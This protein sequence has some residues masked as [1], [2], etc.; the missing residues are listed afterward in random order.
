MTIKNS[1]T[2]YLCDAGES[3]LGTP[4]TASFTQTM[5]QTFQQQGMLEFVDYLALSGSDL[6][7]DGYKYVLSA[8][9]SPLMDTVLSLIQ[10]RVELPRLVGMA[11]KQDKRSEKASAVNLRAGTPAMVGNIE[12]V[13]S[14]GLAPNEKQAVTHLIQGIHAKRIEE[15]HL[16][17]CGEG[18]GLAIELAHA[19]Q[20]LFPALPVN[21]LCL[22][23]LPSTPVSSEARLILPPNVKRFNAL[24]AL[25]D[26]RLARIPVFPCSQTTYQ[27]TEISVGTVR[28]F[29]LE[30]ESSA[31]ATLHQWQLLEQAPVPLEVGVSNEDPPKTV[32]TRYIHQGGLGIR[33]FAAIPAFRLNAFDQRNAY[34]DATPD[35]ST[36]DR[37]RKDRILAQRFMEGTLRHEGEVIFDFH[38][39]APL[40]AGSR[41]EWVLLASYLTGRAKT[42]GKNDRLLQQ[43]LDLVQKK[44]RREIHRAMVIGEKIEDP[45]LL[46]MA[47]A[48]GERA[49]FHKN[50]AEVMDHQDRFG[51]TALIIAA[52]N[53]HLAF[54][55]A[56]MQQ[57]KKPN[58]VLSNKEGYNALQIAAMQGH[59]G[60]M[61]VLFNG[62]KSWTEFALLDAAKLAATHH[63]PAV[64]EGVM[65]SL[66]NEKQPSLS[67][68]IN[69]RE[70]LICAL[71]HDRCE[72]MQSLIKNSHYQVDQPACPSTGKSLLA[73]SKS[74][75]SPEARAYLQRV[76]A[77]QT[78][79]PPEPQ[80][81]GN[82]AVA[83]LAGVIALGGLIELGIFFAGHGAV[84]LSGWPHAIPLIMAVVTV[85]AMITLVY[86]WP[87]SAVPLMKLDLK[88]IEMNEMGD[89]LDKKASL[90][91]TSRLYS[92]APV[93]VSSEPFVNQ[94]DQ[95]QNRQQSQR[96]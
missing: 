4:T 17:G 50:T 95:R 58:K 63:Q 10:G 82:L 15:V 66:L 80:P 64:V 54:V 79:A 36:L 76:H 30:A 96:Y 3:S 19:L 16:I 33:P 77:Q 85:V 57:E 60:I 86:H 49:I 52:R 75:G 81:R 78:Q 46:L 55:Q 37:D 25:N 90:L 72:L 31:L 38:E 83:S 9:S 74:I 18:G 1:F 34:F 70:I 91:V 21:L 32:H 43:A 94:G 51:D 73:M 92:S 48:I 61:Q 7:D 29:S 24:Y 41:Y 27:R 5:L 26:N 8:S 68:Q 35:S 22:E 62:S 47:A 71:E 69:L 89:D 67:I 65:L 12:Q 53:G 40:R 2:V 42:R 45:N 28:S 11:L 87:R 23:P 56:M 84:P 20:K 39:N 6:G 44:I 59:L 14:Q 93:I 13:L 88:S